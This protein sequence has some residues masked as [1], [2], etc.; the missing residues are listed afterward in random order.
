MGM[1]RVFAVVAAVVSGNCGSAPDTSAPPE[2][3]QALSSRYRV[4]ADKCMVVDMDPPDAP[5]RQYERHAWRFGK[6][7]LVLNSSAEGGIDRSS[8]VVPIVDLGEAGQQQA[9]EAYA[10][11]PAS[12][13]CPAL[14]TR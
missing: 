5:Q 9:R 6:D 2:A 11:L 13:N 8:A 14:K 10:R 4:Y 1:K 3:Q 7:I 12:A